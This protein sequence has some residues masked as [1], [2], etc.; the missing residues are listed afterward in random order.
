MDRNSVKDARYPE[1][2]SA[3]SIRLL[4]LG[5]F[6]E[7]ESLDSIRLDVWSVDLDQKPKYKALSYTWGNPLPPPP[8]G[9]PVAVDTSTKASIICNGTQLTV[10]PNLYNAL[11]RLRRR[12]PGQQFWIDGICINQRDTADRN[13]QVSLMGEIYASAS[14]VVVW[15]GEEDKHSRNF[16]KL[17]D[18]LGPVAERL[19]QQSR[20]TDLRDVSFN[21]L[22]FYERQGIE[23]IPL[24]WW[25]SYVRFNKRTWL[26]RAWVVQEVVL[27]QD[28]LMIC[29]NK[30]VCLQNLFC[31]ME[32]ARS[33]KW[34][35]DLAALQADTTASRAL[36]PGAQLRL[37]QVLSFQAHNPEW[38]AQIEAQLRWLN[39][40]EN[41]QELGYA[42]LQHV[43]GV[44]RTFNA[45]EPRDKIYAALGL[46]K[47]FY[48]Q[49]GQDLPQPDYDL[50][51]WKVYY[52]TT[53]ILLE[54]LR[55]RTI[56]SYVTQ[57]AVQKTPDLPS[58]VP[59]FS[60]VHPHQRFIELGDFDACLSARLRKKCMAI[61]GN[62]LSLQAAMCGDIS[63]TSVRLDN[64]ESLDSA[65]SCLH[66]GSQ[67]DAV[68]RNG[69]SCFE[70]LWR[71]M[72]ADHNAVGVPAPTAYQS[73]F[74]RLLL[75]VGAQFLAFSVSEDVRKAFRKAW[76]CV[77]DFAVAHPGCKLPSVDDAERLA[78]RLLVRGKEEYTQ[79]AAAFMPF[80]QSYYL[81]APNR[82]FFRT[83]EGLIGLCPAAATVG[84]RV[85][86]LQDAKVPF[87]LRPLPGEDKM[88]LVG[89]AYVHGLMH[90]EFV[91]S[92]EAEFR[93]ISLV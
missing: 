75:Y 9:P 74:R 63:E 92:G 42:Y 82:K 37:I 87:V 26:H 72:I 22:A 93:Y 1:L 10:L 59:D 32:F 40:I 51:V 88:Q 21:D 35:V 68:Y 30:E 38:R 11:L 70:A 50:P 56:L 64:Y 78:V 48:P 84:D 17:I 76:A 36:F 79:Q 67:L 77:E 85:A 45:S 52:E 3:R 39:G 8:E 19:F 49:V 57:G 24:D 91:E 4:R 2:T 81:I 28:Y 69:Q 33:N 5:T 73:S 12:Y 31:V 71:T 54:R 16:I 58:W 7:D 53:R 62:V 20:P 89:E 55:F 46:V 14:E 29:G 65:M 61:H 80:L 90:G 15:L 44:M 25:K 43:L 86:I 47:N 23:L 34:E 18:R 83:P 60:E 13:S 6:S 27:S 66:I 41:E